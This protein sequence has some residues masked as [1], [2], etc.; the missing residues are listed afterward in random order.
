MLGLELM[1]R[2]LFLRIKVRPPTSF[3]GPRR[4]REPYSTPY[5]SSST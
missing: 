3:I 5:S 2:S 1:H 4:M